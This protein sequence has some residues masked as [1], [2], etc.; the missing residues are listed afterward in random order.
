[1]SSIEIISCVAIGM[2]LYERSHLSIFYG[3]T[4]EFNSLFAVCDRGLST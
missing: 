1:M 2:N 4:S 3:A